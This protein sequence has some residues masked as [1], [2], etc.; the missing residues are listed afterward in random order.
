MTKTWR[1]KGWDSTTLIV[2]RQMP[3]YLSEKEIATTLQRLVSRHL[4]DEDIIDASLR[5]GDSRYRPLLER[6]GGGAPIAY[7]ENPHYTADLVD[8]KG[9]PRAQQAISDTN[10]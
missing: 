1:I 2:D 8:G 3:G 7:G 5:R 10:A 6:V 9:C 4:S